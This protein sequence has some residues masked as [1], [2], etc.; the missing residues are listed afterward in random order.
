M[1]AIGPTVAEIWRYFDF[2]KWPSLLSWMLKFLK[3]LTVGRLKRV[4]LRHCAKFRR[5]RGRDMA[6]FR[7]FQEGGRPPSWICYVC[8]GTTHKGHRCEKFSWNRCSSFDNMHVFAF[9]EFG[10]KTPIHVPKLGFGG[11][12]PLNGEQ[13]Q[14]NPKKHIFARVRVV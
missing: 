8:V 13:C 6:I 9:H 1:A 10:L 7:F 14:Q 3:I 2:S 4:E 5:N 11:F 12:Y